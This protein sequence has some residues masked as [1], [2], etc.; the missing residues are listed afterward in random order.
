[1]V[2]TTALLLALTGAALAQ[3][4]PATAAV[5]AVAALAPR[6]GRERLRSLGVALA[7]GGLAW[8]VIAMA[9]VPLGSRV[10]ALYLP[11]IAALAARAWALGTEGARRWADER[12]SR[13]VTASTPV[14]ASTPASTPARPAEEA[15]AAGLK[16]SPG[17]HAAVDAAVVALAALPADGIPAGE[18]A[19][20]AFWINAYNLLSRHANRGR[21]SAR[22]LDVLEVFRTRY[23]IAGLP[24]T[25]DEIEHGLLRDG[26]A[27]PGMPWARMGRGD[28]RRRFAVPLDPQ[29]HFA[30][31]C[32]ASSCPPVRVFRGE[33]LGAQLDLSEQAFLAAESAID[34]AAGVLETSRIVA[35]Y[36]A[37]FGG[38]AA[39]RARIARAL[40]VEEDRIAGLGMRYRAYDWSSPA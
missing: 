25:L 4:A 17:D 27:P 8:S 21:D 33:A 38:E 26:R 32:G 34:E 14:I 9:R 15:V 23:W 11:A 18:Q 13:G 30:L 10:T 5:L 29:I 22:L 12:W 16:A 1:M 2:G 6:A 37:D 24:L 20:R 31:N 35:W 7:Y 36:A 40:G 19:R 3:R 28:P 39:V